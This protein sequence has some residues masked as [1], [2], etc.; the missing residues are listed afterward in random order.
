MSR[1]TRIYSLLQGFY[2]ISACFVYTFA[3][4]FLTA[5]GF[6]VRQVGIVLASANA[7]SL[8]LQPALADLADRENAPSLRSLL[9]MCLFAAVLF[10]G[11][12]LFPDKSLVLIAVLFVC[13][14]TVTLTIQPML[15]SVGLYYVDQGKPIN[16]SLAR[17]IASLAFAVF[18]Y[19]AGHLAEWR[20]DSLLW[21]YILASLALLFVCL[22]FAP[23]KTAFSKET[24]P[25]SGTVALLKTHPYLLPFLGGVILTYA[26]HNYINAFMLSIVETIGCGTL[27]MSIAI[28]LAAL[29]EI[30]SM[31]GFPLLEKRFRLETLLFISFCAFVVKHLLILV[32][33]LWGGGIFWVYLSQCMQLCG[34]AVFI[35]ASSFWI[36]RQMAE[37][38][39]VKGQML[40]TEA[41]TVGCIIG[42]MGG[43]FLIDRAGIPF[44]TVVGFVF[45]VF[46][47]ILLSVSLSVHK[48]RLKETL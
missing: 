25:A 29:F 12:L 46:G 1:Y 9:S 34:Y 40:M 23:K 39:K 4:R 44:T 16:Y 5:Y 37:H 21:C 41:M 42:Q 11:V 48:A 22:S 32:P 35:L 26:M 7:A 45:S 30:P 24:V 17:A 18:T 2:W 15:N 33:L 20:S 19:L 31:V 6:S 8:L 14:S 3:E 27:E 10:A 36:N 47:L 43:G 13:L 28:A 38:D